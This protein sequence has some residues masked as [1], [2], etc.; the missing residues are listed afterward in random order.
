MKFPSGLTTRELLAALIVCGVFVAAVYAKSTGLFARAADTIIVAKMKQLH[1]VTRQM[2][3]DGI[4]TTN[5]RLG[6]PGDIGGT[7]AAWADGLVPGYL[8]TNGFD[9]LLSVRGEKVRHGTMPRANTNGIL[10]YA[11]RSNSAA[12][13]VL[14]TTAN[15]TNTPAGGELARKKATPLGDRGFVVFRKGGDGAIL[16]ASQAGD[17]NLVGGFAPLCR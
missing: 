6:W 12:D 17:T 14:F 16:L 10:L 8:T 2:A 3:L 13:T 7:F 5:A 4:E 11:V 15:F 1:L 9:G